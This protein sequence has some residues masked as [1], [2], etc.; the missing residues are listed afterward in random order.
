MTASLDRVVALTKRRGFVFPS[1]EI[2]GGLQATYDYG[3]ARRRAQAP[4]QGRLVAGAS[5][6]T[7]RTSSG[8]TPRSSW[9][10]RVWEVSGH[11]DGFNDPLVDCKTCKGRFRADKIDQ[12]GLP[13]EALEEAAASAA[14]S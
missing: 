1:S 9:R 5:C 14:A 3:P 11:V 6:A 2:Y 10:R 8:S 4:D 13:E 12:A 7:A